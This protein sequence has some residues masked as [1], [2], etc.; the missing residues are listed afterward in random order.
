MTLPLFSFQTG[1]ENAKVYNIYEKS[2]FSVSFRSILQDA[3]S[4]FREIKLDE[5][6]V[7]I[8]FTNL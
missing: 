5:P 1:V 7:R 4:I 3:A 8:K 6:S 2:D